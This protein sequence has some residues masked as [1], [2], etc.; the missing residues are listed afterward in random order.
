MITIKYKDSCTEKFYP[1]L[2]LSI[3]E[4]NLV[5][6]YKYRDENQNMRYDFAYISL[7]SIYMIESE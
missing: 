4:D 3:E 5:I 2:T 6:D 7:I 1:P